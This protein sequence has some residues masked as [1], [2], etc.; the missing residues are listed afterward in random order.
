MT[1]LLALANQRS[2]P[3]LQ[4]SR[5]RPRRLPHPAV[6]LRS[7]DSSGHGYQR[8]E[9]EKTVLYKIV[10]EHLEEFLGEIHDHYDK[11]LPKHVEKELREYLECGL[12]QHG[13]AKAVC[14]ACGRTICSTSKRIEA[15]AR[16]PQP[17]FWTSSRRPVAY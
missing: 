9:P 17:R 13:F 1:T 11:P 6:I 10:S 15:R 7:S 16:A 5:M 14:K 12:L 8:H 4:Q 3:P 2:S